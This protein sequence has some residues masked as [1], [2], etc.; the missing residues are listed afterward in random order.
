MDAFYDFLS[1]SQA[2]IYLIITIGG[3]ALFLYR[4][5]KKPEQEQDKRI[6]EIFE[7]LTELKESVEQLK[8]GHLE[9]IKVTIR[10]LVRREF[11]RMCVD[12]LKKGYCTMSELD[13]IETMYQEYHVKYGMNGKGDELYHRV[14][15]L[16]I[17]DDLLDL[18]VEDE[19]K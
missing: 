9:D 8:T 16:R 7:M 3:W 4:Q 19:P 1:H 13:N 10:L 18:E 14:L 12:C 5:S 15:N 11:N 2:L 17:K 6:D